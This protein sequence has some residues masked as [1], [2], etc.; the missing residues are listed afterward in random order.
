MILDSKET[1]PSNGKGSGLF[2][3][4]SLNIFHKVADNSIDFAKVAGQKAKEVQEEMKA[5]LGLYL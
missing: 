1:L 3:L 2:D 4:Y 5:Y